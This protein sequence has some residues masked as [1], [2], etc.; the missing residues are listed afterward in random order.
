MPRAG[1]V[2]SVRAESGAASLTF[3][4]PAGVAARIRNRMA[5]GSTQIDEARFPRIGDV[6]QSLDYATAENRIDMDI[7]GGVGSLRVIAGS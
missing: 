1:G 6:Y 7:Q 4:I 5:L 3:E 2:T